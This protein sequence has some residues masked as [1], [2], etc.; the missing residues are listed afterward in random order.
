VDDVLMVVGLV[1]AALAVGVAA[2][3]SV[4][5]APLLLSLPADGYARAQSFYAERRDP[6]TVVLLVGTAAVDLALA[7]SD[8]PAGSRLLFAAGAALLLSAAAIGPA[9]G[10]TRGIA[11]GTARG[12]A[13]T[14]TRATTWTAL[15]LAALLLTALAVGVAAAR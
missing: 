1:G 2:G 10:A 12:S 5:L 6:L 9:V 13:A 8:R 11:P 14:R 3:V 7:A 15:V 4:A